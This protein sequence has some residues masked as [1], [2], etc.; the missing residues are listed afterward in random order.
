[1]LILRNEQ[2]QKH[3]PCP[4]LHIT[5]CDSLYF[6]FY[7]FLSFCSQQSEQIHVHSQSNTCSLALKPADS[8]HNEPGS[9][10]G[11]NMYR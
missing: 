4:F 11:K 5:R 1:M 10:C 9:D 8:C 7:L 2:W 3:F 6:P